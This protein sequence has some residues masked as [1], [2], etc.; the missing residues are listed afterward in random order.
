MSDKDKNKDDDFLNEQFEQFG[1]GSREDFEKFY[2]EYKNFQEVPKD[3]KDLL[4]MELFNSLLMRVAQNQYVAELFNK[5]AR[6]NL[7]VAELERVPDKIAKFLLADEH[8]GLH[9]YRSRS[10]TVMKIFLN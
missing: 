2:E 5:W 1:S 10:G 7:K 8:S 4:P 9:A 6:K 3:P